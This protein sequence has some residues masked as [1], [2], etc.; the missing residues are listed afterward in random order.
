M[1][2]SALKRVWC[3]GAQH[4]RH[5]LACCVRLSPEKEPERFVALAEQL[6]RQ[7]SLSRLGLTP[8]LCG[9]AKG[10]GSPITVFPSP[11]AQHLTPHAQFVP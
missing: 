9:S 8:I 10:G 7:G 2:A 3:A 4:R 6:Q 5:L 11:L 1:Q